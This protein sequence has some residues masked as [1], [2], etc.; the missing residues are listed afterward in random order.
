MNIGSVSQRSIFSNPP[1]PKAENSAQLAFD[2]E[3]RRMN[4]SGF[5]K[6]NLAQNFWD[7]TGKLPRENQID[8]ASS[9]V[10][11]QLLQNGKL[12]ENRSFLEGMKSRFGSQ[13]IEGLRNSIRSHRLLQNRSENEVESWLKKVGNFFNATTPMKVGESKPSKQ[14]PTRLSS[15]EAIFFQ[16][17]LLQNAHP[18]IFAAS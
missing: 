14:S 11:N 1:R 9:V 13:D 8:L 3:E 7:M 5:Q 2:T 16:R 10:V 12:P 18:N 17:T 4:H 6:V 15:P